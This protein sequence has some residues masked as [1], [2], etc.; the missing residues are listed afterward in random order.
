ML[1]RIGRLQERLKDLQLGAMLI[2]YPANRRYIT[3]FTGSEGIILITMEESFLITDFRYVSQVKEQVPHITLMEHQGSPFKTL[4]EVC[5]KKNITAVAFEED[6]LTYAA[7]HEL[8]KALEGVHLNPVKKVVES[9]RMVK[10]EDELT[11][12]RQAADIADHAFTQILSIIQ[13]GMKEK[14]VALRLEFYMRETGASSSSFN[15]IVASGKRS[16]LPHGIASDKELEAGDLVTLDFG[17]LY[18]GY[19]SDITR[20]IMLGTPTQRQK[21]IYDIV[22]T[23]QMETIERIRPGM[24]GMEADHIAR[25]IITNRGYGEFFGHGTGHGLGSEVHEDPRLSKQGKIEL[26]PGMVVTVEPGIY[27]PDF[28]GVRIEDDIVITE[29]GCEVLTKSKKDLIVIN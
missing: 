24:T 26:A 14:E 28:G 15:I 4:G 11:T 22:L 23:A 18:K 17:A 16:A 20:T 8:Q 9:L 3:G 7:Y 21:E 27:L 19:A 6:H 1:K 29:T 10:D 2:T 25:E 5:A 13:P 12:I